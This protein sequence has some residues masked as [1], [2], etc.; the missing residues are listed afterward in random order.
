MGFTNGTILN[1]KLPS[2]STSSQLQ[3]PHSED[4]SNHPNP[5]ASS[6]SRWETFT[7]FIWFI[8]TAIGYILQVSGKKTKF[9]NNLTF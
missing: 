8:I 5:P 4:S 2:S 1:G 3:P 7:D 6:Y 9:I